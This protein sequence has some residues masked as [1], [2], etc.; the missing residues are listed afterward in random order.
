M[1]TT[2]GGGDPGGGPWS[3]FSSHTETFHPGGVAAA[4]AVS[5]SDGVSTCLP[6]LPWGSFG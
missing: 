2:N 1:P 4:R 5:A 6:K 3:R